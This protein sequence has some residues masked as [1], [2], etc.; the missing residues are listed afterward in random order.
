MHRSIVIAAR[1]AAAV[2]MVLWAAGDAAA[3][4]CSVSATSVNFG[5]Y[6]VF[7]S[8]PNDSTGT[9][10][11]RCNG[12]AKDVAVEID[13]GGASTFALRRMVNGGSQLRYNLY[14]NAARTTVWGDGT[15]GTLPYDVGNPPNNKDVTLTIFGRIAP[16]QD[17]S[18]G[19]YSDSV[20]V[21]VNY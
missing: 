13:R 4:G 7:D 11:L 2:A 14:L 10:T 6:D 20:T 18:S 15:G 19:S 3:A 12:G 5:T 9:I 17:V 21:T 8:A 16:E 1:A